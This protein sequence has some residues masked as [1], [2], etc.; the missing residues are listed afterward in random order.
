[1]LCKQSSVVSW[2]RQTT[3][4]AMT[5]I[6]YLGTDAGSFPG[7]SQILILREG[8]SSVQFFCL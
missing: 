4:L 8:V 7:G 6:G 3:T 5:V 2:S 1:M